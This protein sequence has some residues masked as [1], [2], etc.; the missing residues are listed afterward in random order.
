MYKENQTIEN[1]KN[2]AVQKFGRP[3]RGEIFKIQ[4]PG[5][6]CPLFLPD[7]YV[8]VHCSP[9]ENSRA[10][11]EKNSQNYSDRVGFQVFLVSEICTLGDSICVHNNLQFNYR[12]YLTKYLTSFVSSSPFTSSP[13]LELIFRKSSSKFYFKMEIQVEQRRLY[14]G[15]GVPMYCRVW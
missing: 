2:L 3:T 15:G 14:L 9:R 12:L 4:L 7:P 1:K 8:P 6:N 5:E 13:S 11:E 10:E